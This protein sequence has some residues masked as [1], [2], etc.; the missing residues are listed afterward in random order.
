MLLKVITCIRDARKHRVSDWYDVLLSIVH[1]LPLQFIIINYIT[2]SLDPVSLKIS[3]QGKYYQ[4][5]LA[6]PKVF[7]NLLITRMSCIALI[8]NPT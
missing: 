7:L 1:S 4:I 6:N 8:N 5:T 3:K 2:F